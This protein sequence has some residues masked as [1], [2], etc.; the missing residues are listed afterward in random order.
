MPL[1]ARL[2][3]ETEHP[4]GSLVCHPRRDNRAPRRYDIPR[5]RRDIH[6]ERLHARPPL[7]RPRAR[8]GLGR[9]ERC[10]Q[11]GRILVGRGLPPY[12]RGG[13]RAELRTSDGRARLANSVRLAVEE[14]GVTFV[15]LG[16]VLA[17]RRD[18]LP[19]GFVT[20]S[21]AGAGGSATAAPKR[22]GGHRPAPS[23]GPAPSS[24]SRC[25]PP[26]PVGGL[27]GAEDPGRDGRAAAGQRSRVHAAFRA[28]AYVSRA[29]GRSWWLRAA[30]AREG[31]GAA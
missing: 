10:S 22:A 17:T 14:G 3:E 30:C 23:G 4:A 6:P 29:G 8:N 21:T 15:K 7:S 27:G 26:E 28:C 9:T 25:P 2:G 19:D 5:S 20:C 31:I 18:L 11:I 24:A 1:P 16:Q 13:R 12:L